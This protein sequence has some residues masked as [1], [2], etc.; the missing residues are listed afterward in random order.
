MIN[1][2]EWWFSGSK[3]EC[4]NRWFQGN[5][6]E[7]QKLDQYIYDQYSDQL[8]YVESLFIESLNI[9]SLLTN[10]R[11]LENDNLFYPLSAI[12][13]LDQF[14]RH[15]Y[16]S[17]INAT[18][19]ISRNTLYAC[20]LALEILEKC[21]VQ[22]LTEFYTPAQ[23]A[24]LLMPLKHHDTFLCFDFIMEK[25]QQFDYN[26]HPQLVRFYKD[27]IKRYSR[28]LN[29]RS[30]LKPKTYVIPKLPMDYDSITE[31]CP[32][33]FY[34]IKR[35]LVLNPQGSLAVV[36]STRILESPLYKIV[37][38]Q[39]CKTFFMQLALKELTITISLSGGVDSM[40]LCYIFANLQ[41]KYPFK[42]QAYHYN[43]RNR[44]E[45]DEEEEFVRFY[46]NRLQIPIFVRVITEIHR[47]ENDR[48]FY[49]DHTKG[50]RFDMYRRISD[51]PSN[52]S[53]SNDSP[54]NDSPSNDQKLDH[55]RSCIVL[56]HIC[57]DKI[58]NIWTNFARGRDLFNLQ[59]MSV[60]DTMFGVTLFR[61]FLNVTKQ[62]ILDF[63]KE[64]GIAFLLN[65]TPEWS[66]RGKFRNEFLPA[67]DKQ[68][69]DLAHGNALFF[70]E[71]LQEYYRV[72]QDTLFS[73]LIDSICENEFGIHFRIPQNLRSLGLHFW[74]T[75][76]TTIFQK[77]N[78]GMSLPSRKSLLKMIDTFNSRNDGFITLKKELYCLTE[79]PVE[80]QGT[81]LFL[82]ILI[83]KRIVE[84]G[85]FSGIVNESDIN[86]TH[87][88]MLKKLIKIDMK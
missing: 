74:Q 63:S 45:S 24:F 75:I 81:D 11:C 12:I 77:Y 52:D 29:E 61:P 17:D 56:G 51:S 55:E 78:F 49:E 2:A 9:E 16:R 71:S 5:V 76:F 27:L 26:R 4:Q 15:I 70:A 82:I 33:S 10:I 21:D 72:L 80:S 7:R 41:K 57:D 88:K 48:E 67:I 42:L 35:S 64:Y 54:S 60:K 39:L 86:G 83:K 8:R 43:A 22:L 69:T 47:R 6:I 14:S 58:E 40:V 38:S 19:L 73:P 34:S 37:E 59:K 66:N 3:Q 30:S 23:I 84:S 53:P 31:Y 62:S 46:C 20:A 85:K 1:I 25:L 13:I 87:W 50:I 28:M 65:S 18:Q 36:S 44:P 32:Q 68:Y 79:R